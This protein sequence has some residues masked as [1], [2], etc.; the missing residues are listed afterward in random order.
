M[1]KNNNNQSTFYTQE[2][3]RS[4]QKENDLMS[5]ELAE[6]KKILKELYNITKNM[7]K[8]QVRFFRGKKTE[9]TDSLKKSQELERSLDEYL[10]L[11][12][13]IVIPERNLFN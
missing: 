12:K 10:F 2:D 6:T 11:I 7:R 4:M 1:E 3:F 5:A 13:N 9:K 8:E